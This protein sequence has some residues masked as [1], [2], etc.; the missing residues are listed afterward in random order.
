MAPNDVPPFR[1]ILPAGWEER[2]A[3]R[4]SVT[5]LIE[6]A[7]VVF[8]SQHRPDLDSEF[9]QLMGISLHK[10]KQA[11]V[12]AVY[13]QM[14]VP[15]EQVLPLSMTAALARGQLGGTL[16]RQ[17]S[18]LFR[19]K[20]AEFLT[21]DRAIVRWQ[22]DVAH[23]GKLSG[24]SSRNLNYLVA[25]PGTERRSAVQFTTTIPYPT[26]DDVEND[27]LLDDITLLSDTIISTFAWEPRAS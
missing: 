14:S 27:E 11:G 2:P 10:M 8:Q 19:E 24:S 1:L 20:K 12:F 21:D 7:R 9:S 5:V 25:I 13:L 15:A 23:D 22:S 3:D 4:E 18:S 6:R 16:D 17:V 26:G